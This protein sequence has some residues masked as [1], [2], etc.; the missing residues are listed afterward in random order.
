MR[1]TF[2]APSAPRPSGGVAVIYEMASAMARRGHHVD[3][4][5]VDLFR[6]AVSSVDEL[7]WFDFPP[8]ITRH[9]APAGDFNPDVPPGVVFGFPFDTE[10]PDQVLPVV[11]IQGYKMLGDDVERHA[12]EARCP[13]ICVARWLVDIGRALGVPS[14]ELVH[15]PVGLRHD[16]FHL[17]RPV[18]GRPLRIAYCYSSHAMKGAPL[19]IDV[20]SQVKE[21]VPEV[22]VVMF[23][24]A[25]P[26]H[27]LPDWISYV[28]R[29][30]ERYL[31]DEIYNSSRVFL[32]TSSVEGFGLANVE[33]MA[34]GA[35]LVTTANG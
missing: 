23:G 1:L 19:A 13:K 28:T 20:L 25:A 24:A 32:C 9:F 5:H 12:Y 26:E 3:L 15:V 17:T 35:A 22:E 31:V 8:G 2:I 33:A 18:E 4:F 27:D 21:K 11:L 14:N 10:L 34:C 6:S 30:D 29:P 16:T 7:D